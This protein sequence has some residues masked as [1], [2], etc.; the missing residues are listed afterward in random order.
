MSTLQDFFKNTSKILESEFSRTSGIKHSGSKGSDRELF[1]K[2]FLMKSFPKKFVIGSGEILDSSDNKSKQADIVIYD[3][4]M[5]VF[6]YGSTK[7]FLSGGVFAHIEIKSYLDSSKLEEALD[8]TNSIK[9]LKRDLE[10]VTLSFG[11]PPKTIFSC[12]FAYDGL[13][14]EAF[15]K[16]FEKYYKEKPTDIENMVDAICVLNKYTMIKFS[17][18]KKDPTTGKTKQEIKLGFL[19]TNNDSLM[20][21]FARLFQAVCKNWAGMPDLFKYLGDPKDYKFF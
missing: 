11:K 12:I 8:I 18:P 14:K 3:E 7:H 9:K 15:N 2:E 19:E 13:S 20:I 17:L 6:D 21:F 10:F 4:F 1:I 5:P 16:S